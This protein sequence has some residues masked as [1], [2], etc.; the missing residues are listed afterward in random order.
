MEIVFY[1]I[2]IYYINIIIACVVNILNLTRSSK[3]VKDFFL[4]TFLPYLLLNLKKEKE[5]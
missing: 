5:I 3:N 1:F 4:L 2:I